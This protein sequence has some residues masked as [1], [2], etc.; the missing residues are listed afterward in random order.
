VGGHG[1]RGRKLVGN[2]LGKNEF[3]RSNTISFVFLHNSRVSFFYFLPIL[4]PLALPLIKG[5]IGA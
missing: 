5:S 3:F 2:H 4:F 1:V